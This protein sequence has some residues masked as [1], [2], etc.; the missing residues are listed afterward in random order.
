MIHKSEPSQLFL[1]TIHAA[2]HAEAEAE[3]GGGLWNQHAEVTP[4]G[5][6]NQIVRACLQKLY[7]FEAVFAWD[8]RNDSQQR[9][10]IA[11]IAEAI[12][13]GYVPGLRLAMNGRGREV[14]V[15]EEVGNG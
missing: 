12:R 9:N 1:D 2:Y 4:A 15:H 5:I 6:W 10:R 13:Q 8:P 7:S 11:D 3:V 14:V